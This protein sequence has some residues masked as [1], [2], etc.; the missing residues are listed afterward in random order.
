MTYD[1]QNLFF[2]MRNY[3]EAGNDFCKQLNTAI[4]HY[5][6]HIQTI[7]KINGCDKRVPFSFLLL[8]RALK[9]KSSLKSDVSSSIGQ[10]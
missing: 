4:L 3:E 2:Y 6:I 5:E 9:L 1:N 10:T 8:R 7:V